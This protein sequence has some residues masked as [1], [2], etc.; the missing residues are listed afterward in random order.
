[1]SHRKYLTSA[2]AAAAVIGLSACGT[3]TGDAHSDSTR[4]TQQQSTPDETRD[5]PPTPLPE[6]DDADDMFDEAYLDALAEEGIDLDDDTALDTADLVCE[7]DDQGEGFI[8]VTNRVA[9]ETGL[10]DH[11]SGY[12]YGAAIITCGTGGGDA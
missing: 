11:D 12:V 9:T 5:A 1:M 3:S 8:T 10:D 7:L 2:A 4:Q 6:T